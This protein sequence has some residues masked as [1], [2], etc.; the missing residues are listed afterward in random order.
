MG[1]V[2]CV[3]YSTLFRVVNRICGIDG[4]RT[5]GLLRDREAL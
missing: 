3:K 1:Q 5:R 2:S 4:T